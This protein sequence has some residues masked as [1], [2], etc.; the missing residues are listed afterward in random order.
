MSYSFKSQVYPIDFWK[1]TM[2]NTYRSMIGVI[3]IVF[4]FAMFVLAFVFLGKVKPLETGLIILGCVWFPVIQPIIIY[5]HH[6]KQLR[7]LPKDMELSFNDF[8]MHVLTGGKTLDIAWN[9]FVKINIDKH[10][11]ILYSDNQHGYIL[12]D[13]NLGDKKEEFIAFIKENTK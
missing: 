11:I 1:M 6:K 10:M 4:T 12:T 8:G 9:E 7:A 3:N 2:K 13:R 5:F